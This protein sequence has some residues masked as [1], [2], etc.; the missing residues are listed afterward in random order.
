MPFDFFWEFSGS[1]IVPECLYYLGTFQKMCKKKIYNWKI[2]HE[3]CVRTKI[4][5]VSAQTS[6]S[7]GKFDLTCTKILLK[8]DFLRKTMHLL[9]I[10]LSYLQVYYA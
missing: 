1:K 9:L 5:V 4:V 3:H 8:I 6:S 2:L 7:W 10:Q